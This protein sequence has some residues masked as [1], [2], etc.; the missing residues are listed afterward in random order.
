[1]KRKISFIIFILVFTLAF[2]GC[3]K[4]SDKGD[5]DTGNNVQTEKTSTEKDDTGEAKEKDTKKEDD[6]KDIFGNINNMDEYHY[7]M[8][9][10]EEETSLVSMKMWVS[11][12]KIRMETY[13]SE[14]G[15]NIIMI[16]DN[17]EK[18]GYIYDPNAKTAIKIQYN[19]SSDDSEMDDLWDT[20]DYMDV[21]KE[22]FDEEN[23]DI[24][25]G[26]FNGES[27]KIVSNKIGGDTSKMWISKKTSFPLK[28]ETYTEGKLVS[29]VLFKNFERKS[30]DP[31][32]FVVPEGTEIMDMTKM[33]EEMSK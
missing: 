14:I 10:S 33:L 29:T 18:T 27:V 21:I 2:V 32:M 7:E 3:S 1:M 31:S 17:D 11:K 22:V 20:K 26:T 25:N 12:N 6:I 4:G 5:K 9:L 13:S 15:E 30:I 8:E 23:M 19:N 24:E 16:I 28:I